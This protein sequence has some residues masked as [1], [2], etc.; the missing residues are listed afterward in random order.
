MSDDLKRIRESMVQLWNTADA[1]IA[2]QIYADHAARYDPNNPEPIR[3]WAGIAGYVAEVRNAYPDFRL[4]LHEMVAEG[5]LFASH[6]TCT[7]THR[8]EYRGIPPTGRQIRLTGMTLCRVE[9]GRIVEDR[10]YFDR[11]SMFEQLGVSPEASGR[12]T[13]AAG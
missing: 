3:G 12:Q 13:R 9:K 1:N 5:D 8:G 10:V 2:R 4:E 7:G 11:L 6:W